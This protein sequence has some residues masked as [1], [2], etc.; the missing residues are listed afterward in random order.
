MV[1]R[2]ILGMEAVPPESV[3]EKEGAGDG[4]NPPLPESPVSHPE[5]RVWRRAPGTGFPCSSTTRALSVASGQSS[6]AASWTDSETGRNSSA[7]AETK[8]RARTRRRQIPGSGTLIRKRPC[9]SEIAVETGAGLSF[10]SWARASSK[11][12][13]NRSISIDAPRMGL[14]RRSSTTLDSVSSPAWAASE[15]AKSTRKKR[16]ARG[17]MTAAS[18]SSIPLAGIPDDGGDA[19]PAAAFHPARYNSP[20]PKEVEFEILPRQRGSGVGRRFCRRP[21]GVGYGASWVPDLS[22]SC[23]HESRRSRGGQGG[24]GQPAGGRPAPRPARVDRGDLR[25]RLDHGAPGGPGADRPRAPARRAFPG[26][27]RREND[28]DSSPRLVLDRRVGDLPALGLPRSE[29]RR[30]FPS[31][32]AVTGAGG[33]DL[34]S[35]L[36]IPRRPGVVPTGDPP[37][38]DLWRSAASWPA[39]QA[40]PLPRSKPAGLGDRASGPPSLGQASSYSESR[41]RLPDSPPS[42]PPR[43]GVPTRS[44][45]RVSL[46]TGPCRRLS[47]RR[48]RR[49]WQGSRSARGRD[50]PAPS[51]RRPATGPGRGG[52]RFGRKQFQDPQ[53]APWLGGPGALR[54]PGGAWLADPPRT[55]D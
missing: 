50:C 42:R 44:P 2:S 5:D 1:S 16:H 55:G 26:G 49:R 14:S 9:S 34:T 35:P 37:S 52:D 46:Q 24:D 27:R 8:P 25:R 38:R 4:G 11:A 41:P 13:G 28:D 6:T 32:G 20:R 7:S 45:R 22:A 39:G 43:P 15:I 29:A 31:A 33:I 48:R 40:G 12:L 17:C 21:A 30:P 23:R 54:P 3:C 53:A 51:A 10:S 19:D 36:A 47:S 18:A